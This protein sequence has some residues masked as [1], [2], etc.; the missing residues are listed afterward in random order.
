VQGLTQTS[1]TA[2]LSKRAQKLERA[3]HYHSPEIRFSCVGVALKVLQVLTSV[4]KFVNG[5][6]ALCKNLGLRR[7]SC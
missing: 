2:T 3:F 1:T 4:K 6:T 7:A 5:Y